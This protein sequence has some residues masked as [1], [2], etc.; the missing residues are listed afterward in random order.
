[1]A[2]VKR[3]FGTALQR[4]LRG[5]VRL[6]DLEHEL[7]E[8]FVDHLPDELAA[9]VSAQP[10]G[11]TL[12]Q[13]ESDGRALNFYPARRNQ[14][15]PKLAV[16]ESEAKLLRFRFQTEPHTDDLHATFVAIDGRFFCA[17]FSHDLRVYKNVRLRRVEDV[18]QAW[19][20]A[21]TKRS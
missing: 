5:G 11:Y 16:K 10:E 15:L 2:H 1:M 14:H 13:R 9:T 17:S 3:S 6:T 8:A 20:S 19:R 7:L 18:S 21:V 12:V 4:T